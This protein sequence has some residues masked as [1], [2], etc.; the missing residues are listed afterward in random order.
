MAGSK[1]SRDLSPVKEAGAEAAAGAGGHGG[2][3]QPG[4][5]RPT[6]QESSATGES[7]QGSADVEVSDCGGDARACRLLLLIAGLRSA[8]VRE[9][10]AA[11]LSASLAHPPETAGRTQAV[12]VDST[13]L[14]APL[15]TGRGSPLWDHTSHLS[16]AGFTYLPRRFTVGLILR[17]L[18]TGSGFR[19]RGPPTSRRPPRPL[20]VCPSLRVANSTYTHRRAP[21]AHFRISFCCFS[22]FPS[23]RPHPGP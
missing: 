11:H 14:T 20:H 16:M 10:A 18:T 4:P 1:H 12:V 6:L 5:K 7:G 17:P 2:V 23:C 22:S 13:P 9:R 21:S 19:C 3:Q 8:M 15:S